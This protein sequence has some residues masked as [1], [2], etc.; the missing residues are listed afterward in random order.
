LRSPFLRFAALFIAF[1]LIAFAVFLYFTGRLPIK[2]GSSPG[3]A[4]PS[5]E[6]A[7]LPSGVPSSPAPAPAQPQALDNPPD[8]SGLNYPEAAVPGSELPAPAPPVSTAAQ[9]GDYVAEIT[10]QRLALP[11]EG[12][13]AKSI[14]DTFNDARGGG[15]HEATDIMAARGTPVHAIAEGNI[16][17]LFTSKK[18]GLTIYEFD[19]SQKYCFYYAHL[20][21]YADNVK[22]GM[23]VRL[24]QVI[25]YVGSTGDA[26]A[27]NPHLHFAISLLDPDK[28]YWKGTALNPYPVL[29]KLAGSK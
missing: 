25:G 6:M 29:E 22:E 12:V 23:L 17:K 18:G 11:I 14:A 19:N 26:D 9:P 15:K 5:A 8:V 4:S 7:P 16:V 3:A 1:I 28:K 24:G 27:K 21:K 13:P 20:D 2:P 10:S